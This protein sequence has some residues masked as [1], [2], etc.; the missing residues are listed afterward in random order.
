MKF[1][2][3][4]AV[5]TALGMAAD[6][7]AQEKQGVDLL[8]DDAV[9][10]VM[11]RDL[12]EFNRQLAALVN[13]VWPPASEEQLADL[14]YFALNDVDV[15]VDRVINR[16]G[17][18]GLVLMSEEDYPGLSVVYPLSD[19]AA[20][21]TAFGVD[22]DKLQNG[23][24]FEVRD[25]T[26][27]LHGEHLFLFTPVFNF[28][29]DTGAVTEVANPLEGRR[30]VGHHLDSDE[31]QWFG[32]SDAVVM[33]GGSTSKAFWGEML[34]EV[35]GPGGLLT[36]DFEDPHTADLWERLRAAGDEIRFGLASIDLDG[37]L[38][39]RSKTFFR[40]DG[41]NAR[42]LIRDIRGGDDPSNLNCL[43]AGQFLVAAAAKGDGDQNVLAARS[44]L[45]LL[46]EII[47]P[48]EE[49][50]SG[51]DKQRFYQLFGDVWQ[52]L[53]G[54]RL[55]LYRNEPDTIG[56]G[57]G[58]LAV[59]VIMETNDTV[60]LMAQIPELVDFANDGIRRSAPRDGAS[61]SFAWRTDEQQWGDQSIDVLEIDTSRINEQEREWFRWLFGDEAGRLRFA[62]VDGHVI[63]FVGTAP[64]LFHQAIANVRENRAGLQEHA[65][66]VAAADKMDAR[67]KVEL[68][69][70]MAN[71][72]GL[73]EAID[74]ARDEFPEYR[75]PRELSSLGLV[76]DEDRFGF[77]LWLPVRELNS[78]V[79]QAIG[80]R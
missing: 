28:F 64:E 72:F 71:C 29:P 52:R 34:E 66:L 14:F 38:H 68:H 19:P 15:D 30:F 10:G 11:F 55:A 49:I 47:S 70:S 41:D 69:L 53:N 76:I 73:F 3:L 36:D 56:E 5:L 1:I 23:Q 21:A 40:E 61:I 24:S 58:E 7:I 6:T 54:T 44:I 17:S 78:A 13:E 25:D 45:S 75:E 33:L 12:A 43:P 42:E 63:M 8:P 31:R 4:I 32:G 26:L 74:Q 80:G 27:S 60:E 57:G 2:A 77:D 62:A 37:G 18:G 35:V 16:R 59:V 48:G 9:V 65:A 51:T 20:L 67:C 22:V 50:L 39:V 79:E 46:V